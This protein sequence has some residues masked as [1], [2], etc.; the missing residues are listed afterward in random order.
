MSMVKKIIDFIRR[1]FMGIL[2][3]IKDKFGS[4]G[5]GT[6]TTYTEAEETNYQTY[7]IVGESNYGTVSPLP[8]E[9]QPIP[10][11][12][13]INGKGEMAKQL[14]DNP[15]LNAILDEIKEFNLTLLLNTKESDTLTREALFRKIKIVDDI[16]GKINKY[17]KDAER[18]KRNEAESE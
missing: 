10:D 4:A 13:G 2:D 15:L 18:K 5:S 12:I 3:F 6:V 8:Q 14:R 17:I 11:Y 9:A 7:D 16:K 1:V